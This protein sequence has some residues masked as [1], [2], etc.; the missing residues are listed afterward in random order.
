MIMKINNKN[1][2]IIVERS[3]ALS[4][5]INTPSD[6]SISHRAL[7]LGS[8]CIGKTKIHNLLLSEDIMSTISALEEFG[9]NINVNKESGITTVHGFGIGGL[10][11]PSKK[12][13]SRKLRHFCKTIDWAHV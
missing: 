9:A 6:K 11:Q 2:P 7:I 13:L 3:N 5:V 12:N 8:L 4:G 10:L 1:N